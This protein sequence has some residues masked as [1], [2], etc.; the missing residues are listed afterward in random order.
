MT[1][2]LTTTFAAALVAASAFGASTAFAG[3]DYYVGGAPAPVQSQ[4]V[5]TVR[6]N[7]IGSKH[8]VKGQSA[9]A[10]PYNS[11]DYRSMA[12]NANH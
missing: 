11:G 6:T 9:E 2:T 4:N 10:Q 8:I 1:K 7:S 3:G 12:P 5:D